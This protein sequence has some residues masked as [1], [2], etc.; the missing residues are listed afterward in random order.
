[1]HAILQCAERH[2]IR[3]RP[4]TNHNVRALRQVFR[5]NDFSKP[6][7]QPISLDGRLAVFGYDDPETRNA[8]VASRDGKRQADD[9]KCGFAR[10]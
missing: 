2:R 6:P 3:L 7:F 4:G 8:L 9:P 1:V 10:A 5:T